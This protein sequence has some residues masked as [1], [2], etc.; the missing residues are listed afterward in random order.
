MFSE[1]KDDYSRELLLFPKDNAAKVRP[2]ARTTPATP[3]P[4]IPESKLLQKH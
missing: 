4:T 2:P 1:I 3:A